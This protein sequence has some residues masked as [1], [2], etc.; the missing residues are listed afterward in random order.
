MPSL[1]LE[2][3]KIKEWSIQREEKDEEKGKVQ[4]KY[5]YRHSAAHKSS[6]S[7]YPLTVVFLRP[8][9]ISY[10]QGEISWLNSL[11]SQSSVLSTEQVIG[12]DLVF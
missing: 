2:K 9:S 4:R 7:I 11:Y 10:Q 5:V 1:D 8:I 6:S 12:L 3:G